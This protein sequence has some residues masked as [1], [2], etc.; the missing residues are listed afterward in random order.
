MDKLLKKGVT[1][2]RARAEIIDSTPPT[3]SRIK[4]LQ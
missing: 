2:V 3:L 4:A 1:A